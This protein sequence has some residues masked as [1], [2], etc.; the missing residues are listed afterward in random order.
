MQYIFTHYPAWGELFSTSFNLLSVSGKLVA[1]AV[2]DEKDHTE[3]SGRWEA[4]V[5]FEVLAH[6]DKKT[7][8]LSWKPRAV[9]YMAASLLS[10]W[11]SLK[12]IWPKLKHIALSKAWLWIVISLCI[13]FF[14]LPL[15][16]S[17]L[18]CLYTI[19]PLSL[20]GWRTLFRGCPQNTEIISTGKPPCSDSWRDAN[21]PGLYLQL[22]AAVHLHMP[23]W[24]DRFM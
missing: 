11:L 10:V 21:S 9:S 22:S 12:W 7:P 24:T 16:L 14:S 23:P 1:I 20:P 6:C 15:S 13:L 17:S 19:F 2:I 18:V 5:E 8:L 4:A 3:D